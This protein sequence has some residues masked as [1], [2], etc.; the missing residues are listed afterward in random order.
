MSF[1]FNK[2]KKKIVF[3]IPDQSA[4]SG[5]LKA[6]I[7]NLLALLHTYGEEEKF[8]LSVMTYH[9][10]QPHEMLHRLQTNVLQT[11]AS[12][13]VIITNNIARENAFNN[14]RTVDILSNIITLPLLVEK[15]QL[16]N[17][18]MIATH[19]ALGEQL[20]DEQASLAFMQHWADE[21]Q[22]PFLQIAAA[23][24]S[25]N[26]VKAIIVIEPAATTMVWQALLA[27]MKG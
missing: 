21:H 27:L 8:E 18:K 23:T 25:I 22:L 9:E 24:K 14:M 1:N 15:L 2:R 6:L 4:Y 12:A 20:L 19:F 5:A 16:A 3:F 10:Q 26:D 13:A 7:K 11:G 17:I